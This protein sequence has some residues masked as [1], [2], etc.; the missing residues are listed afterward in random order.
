MGEGLPLCDNVV[1]VEAKDF[2]SLQQTN[3]LGGRV[4]RAVRPLRRWRL[5][6]GN[7]GWANRK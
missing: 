5:S 6:G 3:E 4:D 1:V 7:F 2:D